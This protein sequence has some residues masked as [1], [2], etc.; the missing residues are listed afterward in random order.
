MRVTFGSDILHRQ[1]YGGISRYVVE[2]ACGLKRLGLADVNINAFAY[3]NH[4]LHDQAAELQHRGLYVPYRIRGL[5]PTISHVQNWINAVHFKPTDL[6]HLTYYGVDILSSC[7]AKSVA[8]F[9]DMIHER[10]M[11]DPIFSTQ[12]RKAYEASDHCI[13]IS[14][15]TKRDMVEFLGADPDRISVVHL[16]ANGSPRPQQADNV[17]KSRADLMWIGR[18]SD[19]KNFDSFA[20][21][22]ARTRAC[23]DG[24]RIVCAGGSAFTPQERSQ[25][26]SLGIREAQVVRVSP[27]DDELDAMYRRVLALVYVSKFEGFGLP[28]L[29]A[30]TAG[31]PVIASTGGS[32]PEVVGDGGLLC[33]PEDIDAIANAIDQVVYYE[34]LRKRLVIDGYERAKLFSWERC[35][36]ETHDVYRKLM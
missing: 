22:F 14:H 3:L 19:Y 13:A 11:P 9:Y 8:T 2:L 30:M 5:G 17:S 6:V 24:V 21:A 26:Q 27:G 34:S 16:A 33:E 31:C 20:R 1:Q 35:A 4:Y 28:P 23:R 10:Y 7:R 25:W 29:E 12:K 36:R 32:L 18:R 15:A